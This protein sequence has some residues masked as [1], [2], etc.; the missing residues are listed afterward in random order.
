MAPKSPKR[1]KADAADREWSDLQ[2]SARSSAR[3]AAVK[4]AEEQK[5]RERKEQEELENANNAEEDGDEDNEEPA[6]PAEAQAQEEGEEEEPREEEAAAAVQVEKQV[7]KRKPPPKKL[8]A[9]APSPA[10][11]AL[12]AMQL[13]NE[14]M[15]SRMNELISSNAAMAAAAAGQGV[16]A[17]KDASAAAGKKGKPTP[18]RARE[19]TDE[20]DEDDDFAD[21]KGKHPFSPNYFFSKT[22]IG[23]HINTRIA[24]RAAAAHAR[25]PYAF[26]AAS[27][28]AAPNPKLSPWAQQATVRWC[29][30]ELVTV[31][32]PVAGIFPWRLEDRGAKDLAS[33][34]R[35]LAAGDVVR[36]TEFA[37]VRASD[38]KA[39]GFEQRREPAIGAVVLARAE[40]ESIG[41]FVALFTRYA[42]AVAVVHPEQLTP[43]TL[44]MGWVATAMREFGVQAVLV[45]DDSIRQTAAATG[46]P[47]MD[48]TE[49]NMRWL[50]LVQ[51]TRSA[52]GVSLAMGRPMYQ[53]ESSGYAQ[54][55]AGGGRN[56]RGS[57]PHG[58]HHEQ[59]WSGSS[60]AAAP[61][62]A[63]GPSS[64]GTSGQQRE[65]RGRRKPTCHDYNRPGQ[66]CRRGQ[67]NCRFQ[68]A[69]ER[70]GGQHPAPQ[71]TAPASVAAA[72]P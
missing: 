53:R 46:A 40:V 24:A 7:R 31:P 67:D 2:E 11:R 66:Q 10:V 37:H 6:P 13:Q 20:E 42:A 21:K 56:A 23:N 12:M 52:Q 43:L 18:K 68:H 26:P 34:Q 64:S 59:A 41:D 8:P 49:L 47:I 16:R 62:S 19:D 32:E 38:T 14:A 55:A 36:L 3:V 30:V 45:V 71:C 9:A 57:R 48:E 63:A 69:C 72:A 28:A 54:K 17:D 70:C 1:S 65:D 29:I 51:S 39:L 60:S 33:L 15:M 50:S 5:E 61:L 27:A 44:Y 4:A 25:R 58:A 22:I 35:S